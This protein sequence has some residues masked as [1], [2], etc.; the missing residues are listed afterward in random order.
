MIDLSVATF[1]E[2][3]RVMVIDAGR[4]TRDTPDQDLCKAVNFVITP[5][6]C[7]KTRVVCAVI[8]RLHYDLG[9]VRTTQGVRAVFAVGQEWEEACRLI[10]SFVKANLFRQEKRVRPSVPSGGALGEQRERECGHERGVRYAD[11]YG[12]CVCVSPWRWCRSKKR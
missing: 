5:G 9:V 4:I 1:R 12:V 11:P 3:V 2:N 6:E 8:H 10:V 7:E